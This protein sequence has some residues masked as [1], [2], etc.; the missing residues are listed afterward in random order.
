MPNVL[1]EGRSLERQR[2]IKLS[3]AP[4]EVFLQLVDNFDEHGVR[5]NRGGRDRVVIVDG[6]RAELVSV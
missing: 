5:G 3:S 1:L 6:D 2:H 4:V